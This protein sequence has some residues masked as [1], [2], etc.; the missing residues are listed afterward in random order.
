MTPAS[1]TPGAMTGIRVI[2]FSRFLPAAYCSWIFGDM[3]ADVVRI[4]HPRELAK[5]A[6]VF[7]ASGE[8]PEQAHLRRA[9]ATQTRNK[10]SVLLN[11]GNAVAREAIHELIS[12]ADILIEDYRPG[13]LAGMGYAYEDMARL[14]PRLIYVSVSFA[15]RL[16]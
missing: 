15:A 1:A 11:P 14:N 9:R 16:G 7:N 3:D 13:V 8:S 5:E 12:G 2:D 4:E 10:R 6:A